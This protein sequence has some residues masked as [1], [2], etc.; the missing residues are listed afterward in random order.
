MHYTAELPSIVHSARFLHTH[1]PYSRVGPPVLE[2]KPP[3]GAATVPYRVNRG[4]QVPVDHGAL[5]SSAVNSP[6]KRNACRHVVL[7]THESP[8]INVPMMTRKMSMG[9]FERLSHKFG[10]ST[11]DLI[12]CHKTFVR[13]QVNPKG[14]DEYGFIT[15]IGR[16]GHIDPT[17]EQICQ[18]LFEVTNKRNRPQLSFEQV[19]GLL[20]IVKP[21]D[22]L[23]E[24]LLGLSD[25]TAAKAELFFDIVDTNGSNALCMREI[26]DLFSTDPRERISITKERRRDLVHKMMSNV[27]EHFGKAYSDKVTRNEF[28]DAVDTHPEVRRFFAKTLYLA[29]NLQ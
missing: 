13:L 25:A 12:K 24:D 8:F 27:Y 4:G 7:F 26:E 9:E 16:F 6:S 15:F 29:A 23:V 5:L 21:P 22:L 2:E 10:I 11:Q 20:H 14:V 28:L 3:H 1:V 18:R 19:L 17:D